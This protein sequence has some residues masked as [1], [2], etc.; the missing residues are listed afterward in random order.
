M[1]FD[2]LSRALTSG[3]FSARPQFVR[4]V[5]IFFRRTLRTASALP[6]RMSQRGDILVPKVAMPCFIHRGL[7]RLLGML[8]RDLGVLKSLPGALLPGLVILLL[9][10]FRGA[11][12][13][14]A[15]RYVQ[16]RRRVGM[17]SS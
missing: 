1:D 10:G 7:M 12:M 5:P 13:S 6:Q 11:T 9:M 14:W 16:L 2:P 17:D 15:G 4:P 3:G 8:V